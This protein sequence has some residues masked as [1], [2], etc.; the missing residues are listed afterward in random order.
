[1]CT[2]TTPGN[3][4]QYGIE[5]GELVNVKV[6]NMLARKRALEA[7]KCARSGGSPC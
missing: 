2:P 6:D 4:I 7:E 3:A 5:L 1:M